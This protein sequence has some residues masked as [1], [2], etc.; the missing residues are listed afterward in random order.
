[1]EYVVFYSWQSDLPNNLNRSFIESAL[2]KAAKQISKDQNF[3]IEPVIDRDTS[4]LPGSP[5]IT[6]AI[7][8]KIAKSD[9]FVCD[10]SIVNNQSTGRKTPNPNVLLE[11]GYA[12]AVLG[13]DRIIMVQNIAFGGYESIPFDLRDKRIVD[14]YLNN[15][16]AETAE[17][18]PDFFKRKWT[19][20]KSLFNNKK[21]TGNNSK[22]VNKTTTKQAFEDKL[23][24]IFKEAFKHHSTVGYLITNSAIW[25]GNWQLETKRKYNSG[26]VNI[27]RVSSTNF[28]FEMLFADGARTGELHGKA[29]IIAPNAAVAR[30]KVAGDKF[31]EVL[32]RRR[33]NSNNNW[34]IDIDEGTECKYYH[35]HGSSFNGTYNLIPEPIFYNGQL[36]ELDINEIARITGRYNQDFINGFQRIGIQESLDSSI[37]KIVTG[38]IKGMYTIVESI[39]GMNDYGDVWCA[40]IDGDVVRYFTNVITDIEQLPK[41]FEE[42]R[43]RFKNK[44]VIFS[45]KENTKKE[46][47]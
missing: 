22:T 8:E 33:L 47:L 18:K 38:G 24:G 19:N 7:T 20:F 4:G 21:D 29:K 36:D 30:I 34:V 5:S 27:Y 17:I 35:G 2:K 1:M 45:S 46:K 14:Y 11:L 32:F 31:C 23:L 16:L 44:D 39:V 9:L 6:A 13:W 10:I 28:Y 3:T 15:N 40:F 12:S 37:T 42:W 41:T 43:S 26:Y 25:W